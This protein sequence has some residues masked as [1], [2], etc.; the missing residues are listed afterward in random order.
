MLSYVRRNLGYMAI[1]IEE[2]KQMHEKGTCSVKDGAV[3]FCQPW[4]RPV[5]RGKATDAVE[6]GPKAQISHV[7]GYAFLDHIDSDNFN[8]A[9]KLWESIEIYG[10]GFGEKPEAV[11]GD[12]IYGNRENRRKLKEEGIKAGFRPLGRKAQTEEGLK[13]RQWA[14]KK[15]KQPN[16]R[17]NRSCQDSLRT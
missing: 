15:Q 12:Q 3:S 1:L 16:G 8:E 17:Y 6:F 14:K 7:D 9:L 2:L 5:V 11:T 13:H 10:E 4:V